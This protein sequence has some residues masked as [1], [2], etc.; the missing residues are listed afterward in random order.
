[1]SR[2]VA[3]VFVLAAASCRPQPR[4][5]PASVPAPESCPAPA[6]ATT[7]D[8]CDG[9]FTAGGYACVRCTGLEGCLD[10]ET[11]TYCATG[12]CAQDPA[13]RYEHASNR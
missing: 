11:Q 9:D 13:C 12:P 6:N 7:E 1:M 3:F 4:P 5:D 8:I 10:V 2:F